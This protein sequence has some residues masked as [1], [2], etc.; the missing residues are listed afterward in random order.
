MT[1]RTVL[2]YHAVPTRERIIPS[3]AEEASQSEGAHPLRRIADGA[4]R[5]H[6]HAHP[7]PPFKVLC[8]C[9]HPA[10]A[11]HAICFWRVAASST[12]SG[13]SRV[14]PFWVLV[15]C[16]DRD[17]SGSCFEGRRCSW[18]EDFVSSAWARGALGGRRDSAVA[19]GGHAQFG[20]FRRAH[21]MPCGGMRRRETLRA[22]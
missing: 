7:T 16:P 20:N 1:N 21:S 5:V 13:R 19:F 15:G 9:Q 2:L 6:V 10:H 3:E 12:P 11:R 8:A 14:P 22:R 18:R 4:A 17:R